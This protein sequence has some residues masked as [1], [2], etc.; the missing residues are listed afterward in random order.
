[1]SGM[2][3]SGPARIAR[4]PWRALEP[5]HGM[6]Y[7]AS[8]AQDAYARV[9]ITHHRTAYFASRSA[10]LGPVPAE[11]VIATFFNFYPGLVEKAMAG[12]WE[13]VTPAQLLAARLEG[14]DLALRR[15]FSDKIGSTDLA[16]VAGIARQAALAACD[17]G[18]H[19][20]PLFAGHASLAWPDEPHLILWHAQTLLR[21]YRGDGH[22]A[23][24]TAE[25][26]SGVEALVTHAAT[27]DI[28]AELLASS[29]AWPQP[30]WDAAV[31]RL[32]VRG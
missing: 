22:V 24:L 27:N 8:E 30:E 28:P 13:T 4:R 23:V 12:V 26:L 14:A 32:R 7:F 29:R 10:A 18:V 20:R 19:G 1:M 5:V 15:A 16:E 31:D 25:G 3:E 2:P 17:D 11:V 6:I 9:G 21:E